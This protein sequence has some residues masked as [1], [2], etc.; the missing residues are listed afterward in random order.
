MRYGFANPNR[1]L[2]G[3]K[4]MVP[5]IKLKTGSHLREGSE[6]LIFQHPDNPAH[7]IK[8]MM[9]EVLR[10]RDEK[11]AYRPAKRR[12]GAYLSWQREIDEVNAITMRLN[13]VPVFL[14]TYHGLCDT[15]LG[16]GMVVS[17]VAG[18]NGGLAPTLTDVAAA[19][20]LPRKPLISLSTNLSMTF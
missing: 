17:K 5:T 13:K 9:P 15:S 4:K 20:I 12:F 1:D 3:S 11:N 8:V 19:N 16:L 18:K 6:K 10:N 2:S 7:L 14:Q